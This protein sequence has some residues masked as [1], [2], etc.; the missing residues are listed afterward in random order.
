MYCISGILYLFI[1]II[2]ITKSYINNLEQ[3]TN[4]KNSNISME[5]F[6]IYLKNG[7]I[8]GI[9]LP[10]IRIEIPSKQQCTFSRIY[11]LN[12]IVH[13]WIVCCFGGLLQFKYWVPEKHWLLMTYI[14]LM[15]AVLQH[16]CL[17]NGKNYGIPPSRVG[18]EISQ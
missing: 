8:C 12:W 15:M 2:Y 11:R 14:N 5:S 13:F 9:L 4:C 6:H 3:A 10:G 16:T 18:A 17:T 1:M 7:K